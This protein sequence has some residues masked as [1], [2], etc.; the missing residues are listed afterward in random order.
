MSVSPVVLSEDTIQPILR[1]SPTVAAVLSLTLGFDPSVG[2][3]KSTK[4]LLAFVEPGTSF[5]STISPYFC[6]PDVTFPNCVGSVVFLFGSA[7]VF[8]TFGFTKE[9]VNGFAVVSIGLITFPF[10]STG[11][12]SLF[13]FVL[14][15]PFAS[16]G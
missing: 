1:K 5:P 12:P 10:S 16:I 11:L 13:T 8:L 4:P 3:D 2:V 15:L 6:K 7:S 9:E 14:G